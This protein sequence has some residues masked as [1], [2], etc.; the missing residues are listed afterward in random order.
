V[1]QVLDLHREAVGQAGEPAHPHPHREVLALHVTG[2][3]QSLGYLTVGG[4]L[5]TW[6]DRLRLVRRAKLASLLTELDDLLSVFP[7]AGAG[8]EGLGGA[9]PMPLGGGSV[10]QGSWDRLVSRARLLPH[11]PVPALRSIG[12]R[13]PR[14]APAKPAPDA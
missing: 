3:D 2:G 14:P 9:S 13:R 1:G 6:T 5:T 11:A 8:A 4:A 7:R 10:E 12:S